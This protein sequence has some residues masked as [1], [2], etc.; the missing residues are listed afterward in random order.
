[1][2]KISA[3][4]VAL[5]ALS[6]ALAVGC[7]SSPLVAPVASTISVS[8]ASSSLTFGGSTE[9]SAYVIEEA[10]T[11]VQNGTVVRFSATLGRLDPEE[12]KTRDGIARTT[13]IAGSSAGQAQ[14]IA[15]SGG[16]GPVAGQG[17]AANI[18]IGP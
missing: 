9:V 18:T 2:T 5:L 10:G 1:M 16:A 7:D 13:F 17:N 12:A 15:M 4:P 3:R 11:P 8:A 6:A 14:V